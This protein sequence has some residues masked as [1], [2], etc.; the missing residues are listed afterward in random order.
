MV[1]FGFKAKKPN[2]TETEPGPLLLSYEG[3]CLKEEV[4]MSTM[5]VIDV[6]WQ[7]TIETSGV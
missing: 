2:R 3:L 6:T 5:F 1:W 4:I 7:S